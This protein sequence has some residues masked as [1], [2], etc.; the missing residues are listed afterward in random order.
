MMLDVGPI[1]CFSDP[2]EGQHPFN[3]GLQVWIIHDALK[4]ALEVNHIDQVKAD[5]GGEQTEVGFREGA[6]SFSDQPLPSIEVIVEVVQPVE[7][8]GHGCF[9]GVL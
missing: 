3:K 9:V 5:Q 1:A 8:G 6:S 7:E 2:I 4:I